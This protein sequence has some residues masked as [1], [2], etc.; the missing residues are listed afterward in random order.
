VQQGVEDP[1]GDALIEDSQ[2]N[3]YSPRPANLSSC[4]NFPANLTSDSSGSLTGCLTFEVATDALISDVLF[5]P[6][7]QFGSVTAEWKLR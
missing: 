2:D 5:T 7:G 1:A 6:S 4:P 3:L